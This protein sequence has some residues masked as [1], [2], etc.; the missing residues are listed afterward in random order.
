MTEWLRGM[1]SELWTS[2][3]LTVRLAATSTLLLLCIAIP[4]SGWLSNARGWLRSTVELVVTLPIVLPPTVIGFYLLLLLSPA[5][6][7]GSWWVA[8]FG[9][10]LPF[11]FWGLVVGSVL[12][13][14]PFAVQPIQTAFRGIPKS[15]VEAAETMGATR[16]QTYWKILIPLA[17]H[18]IFTGAALSF[19]H[20]M[21]EFG[22]VLMM[23]GNIPGVTRVASIALYDEVQ[24]L[25]YENAH[26][27]ALV[28]LLVSLMLLGFI[29]WLQRRGDMHAPQVWQ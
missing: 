28:L 24:L 18:G 7:P 14:L 10:P 25:R 17:R 19:A 4:L 16:W 15:V 26:V 21:G 20:T 11:S 12:Y 8:L 27:F 5:H 9:H 1:P 23:G 3:W 6:V 22:V 13:S 2:L 29:G